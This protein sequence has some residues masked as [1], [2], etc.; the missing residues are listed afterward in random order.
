MTEET[1]TSPVIKLA[2]KINWRIFS[3]NIDCRFN[4][5]IR[6]SL[7]YF[8]KRLAIKDITSFLI[9]EHLTFS[10]S[11]PPDNEAP[12]SEHLQR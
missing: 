8:L 4:E 1:D 6:F 9:T 3:P 7:N 5:M 11:R 10:F 12:H 2:T